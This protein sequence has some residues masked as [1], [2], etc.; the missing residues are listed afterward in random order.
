MRPVKGVKESRDEPEMNKKIECTNTIN[1]PFFKKASGDLDKLL[2]KRD[3]NESN[4]VECI[5]S[6]IS[7][8]NSGK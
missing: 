8:A 5:T 6:N 4:Q 7:S 2:I 1:C 3:L